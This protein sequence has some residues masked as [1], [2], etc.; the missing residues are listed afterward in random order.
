M[1]QTKEFLQENKESFELYDG[2]SNFKAIFEAIER[3]VTADN[4]I[5]A[6]KSLIEGI[7]KTVISS[8]RDSSPI[9]KETLDDAQILNIR[10]AKKQIESNTIKFSFAFKQACTVLSSHHHSFEKQFF[11]EVGKVFCNVVGD[12][13]NWRGDVSHGRVSSP[14]PNKSSMSLAVMIEKIT[15]TL[16]L[17][18]LESLSLIDFQEQ[19]VISQEV[20]IIESFLQKQ[21]FE[22]E[23]ISEVEQVIRDFNDFLDEQYP[24]EGKPF[25]SRALFDQYQEDYEI[26][27]QEFIDNKEQELME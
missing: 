16:A 18:M 21:P 19:E 20:L 22:L 3:K 17:H 24:L 7:S 15:D 12:I 1:K 9:L 26:Q 8:V 11:D 13:R 25:Y 10:Q 2:F 6:C 23:G 5:E 4:C 27:L 14:K